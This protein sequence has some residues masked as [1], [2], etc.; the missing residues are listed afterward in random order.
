MAEPPPKRRKISASSTRTRTV[1]HRFDKADCFVLIVGPEIREILAHANYMAQ[2]SEVFKNHFTEER[3]IPN[4]TTFILRDVDYSAM[5]DYIAFAY[6]EKLPTAH[7]V[8]PVCETFTGG[9]YASLAQLYLLAMIFKNQA[10]KHAALEEIKRISTLLN[11]DMTATFPGLGDIDIIYNGTSEGDAARQLMV[12]MF[13]EYGNGQ[14][15]TPEYNQT[16]ILD[17]ARKLLNKG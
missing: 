11:V 6:I 15:L 9:E 2:G 17:V 8:R 12:D 13:A 5:T 1:T 3:S 16:F 14:W 7:L 10:L 4:N